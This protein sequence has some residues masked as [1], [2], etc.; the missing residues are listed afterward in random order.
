MLDGNPRP[1]VASISPRLEKKMEKEQP[2]WFGGPGMAGLVA[3]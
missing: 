3:A 1:F 2:R